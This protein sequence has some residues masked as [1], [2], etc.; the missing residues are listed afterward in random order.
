MS[1][2]F[3]PRGQKAEI[4]DSRDRRFRLGV[5]RRRCE[6]AWP[7]LY[8]VH[9]P[10]PLFTAK[11]SEGRTFEISMSAFFPPRGQKA[12]IFDRRQ[13]CTLRLKWTRLKGTACLARLVHRNTTRSARQGCHNLVTILS[14]DQRRSS[15]G[16]AMCPHVV[17]RGLER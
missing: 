8:N 4:F 11:I 1:A 5:N 3:P 13:H 15:A 6:P 2:L 9:T 7:T 14:R 12:E 16:P 10:E 17:L